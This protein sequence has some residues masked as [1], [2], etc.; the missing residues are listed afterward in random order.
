M[1]RILQVEWREPKVVSVALLITIAAAVVVS[2]V[3]APTWG[4][5]ITALASSTLTCVSLASTWSDRN[6]ALRPRVIFFADRE[7][8][9]ILLRV[10]NV[11]L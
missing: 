7:G 10:A 5:V 8:D 2:F 4:A 3:V 11:G 6:E 9:D 1:K